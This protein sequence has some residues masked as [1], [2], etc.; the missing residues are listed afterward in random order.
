[1]RSW[2]LS[3]GSDRNST[4]VEIL[5]YNDTFDRILSFI[6]YADVSILNHFIEYDVTLNYRLMA[7]HIRKIFRE[8]NYFACILSNSD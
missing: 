1:M 7:E 3:L 4:H 5:C 8:R 6:L 2:F